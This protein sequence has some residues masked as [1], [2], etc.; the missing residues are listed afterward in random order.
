MSNTND[1]TELEKMLSGQVYDGAD[2]EI[3]T[4]RSNARKALMAFNNH[5]DP[6]QQHT[7]QEQLFGKVGSSSL[8]QPPF[9]CEFG[10]TI[11][12]GDDTF[13]NMNVVVLDG[14]RI[15]V[16]KNVLIGPSVQF[17]TPSHS[18]DY[19]SR[20]KWETFCLPITIEDDVWVGGNSVINQG[21]TI[22]ARSVIAANSVVNNDVPPDCLY[23]G[24]P[25]K[26]IRYLNTEQPTDDSK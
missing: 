18:L 12:I 25:A 26:L 5:Q 15:K 20:R 4:M 11:E 22:G 13:I 16:G 9:H 23:G 2:Q 1:K 21:V 8:I 24:T 17:Y 10:K 19:R 6:D 3:D 7:L 14:A